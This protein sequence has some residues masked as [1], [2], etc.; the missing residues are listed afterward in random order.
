[1]TFWLHWFSQ[2]LIRIVLCVLCSDID[3]E[4]ILFRLHRYCWTIGR[5]VVCV[6]SCKCVRLRVQRNSVWLQVRWC[7]CVCVWVCVCLEVVR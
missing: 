6:A 7:K 4:F 5:V 1:M 3:G 2:M